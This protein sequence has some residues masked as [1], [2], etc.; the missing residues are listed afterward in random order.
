MI[1]WLH[2]QRQICLLRGVPS[3]G[4]CFL[5]GFC[6]LRVFCLLLWDLPSVVG[7]AL[8]GVWLLRGV[9]PL[10]GSALWGGGSAR[11]TSSQYVSSWNAILLTHL[12]ASLPAVDPGRGAAKHDF[13]KFSWKQHEF[14]IIWTPAG[15]TSLAPPLRSANVY[16]SQIT[17]HFTTKPSLL[18]LWTYFWVL[19][20]SDMVS[21]IGL[22]LLLA[23]F[24]AF[25]RWIL[26]ITQI[27]EKTFR[28]L[29]LFYWTLWFFL[30]SEASQNLQILDFNLPVQ[31]SISYL[32]MRSKVDL[33]VS[34][35]CDQ[36][37][38]CCSICLYLLNFF[39]HTDGMLIQHTK[40][41]FL[42]YLNLKIS[43]IHLLTVSVLTQY[44]MAQKVRVLREKL[45]SI[46]RPSAIVFARV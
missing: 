16:N 25:V 43:L 22:I 1:N 26:Q 39:K 11:P 15:R 27:S 4:V 5:S 33:D 30:P 31:S 12:F 21:R 7:S 36:S 34:V 37:G 38:E 6:H 32:C 44:T 20:M 14:V 8:W 19:S 28:R 46:V 2:D 45:I 24:M 17:R 13:A 9:C 29:A 40:L 23:C 35:Q 3:K 18:H 41:A 10:N 42:Y